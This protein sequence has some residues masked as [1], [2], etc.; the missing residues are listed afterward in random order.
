[1]KRE[2]IKTGKCIWCGRT[3]E[4]GASFNHVPHILPR[5]LGGQETCTDVCNDCNSFFGD[6]RSKYGISQDEAVKGILQVDK[7]YF[8]MNP[9][10]EKSPIFNYFV[11]KH[12]ISLKRNLHVTAQGLTRQFKR[13]MCECFLQK[14]HYLTNDGNSPL[15]EKLRR[16]ARY[17]EGYIPF[18]CVINRIL[19]GFIDAKKTIFGMSKSDID[20]IRR[21]GIF[22]CRIFGH[23]IIMD[24]IP[25]A[26]H[27]E[28][29]RFCDDLTNL[30]IMNGNT[31]SI[32]R[33]DNISQLD[34]LYTRYN[35][36][37]SA[38]ISDSEAYMPFLENP[39]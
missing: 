38:A 32:A 9:Q 25:N 31:L 27:I 23:V 28:K 22:T 13:G 30:G 18:Y 36:F 26:P 2:Y 19:I 20:N 24:V 21:C 3:K 39:K 34:L 10:Q 37:Q 6:D 14:Y 16:F 33:L 4:D 8:T 15:F 12:K 17:D 5:A 11:S 29:M 1:M 35:H 7:H